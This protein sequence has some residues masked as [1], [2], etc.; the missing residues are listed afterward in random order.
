MT[1]NDQFH[2]E[3]DAELIKENQ[4]ITQRETSVKIGISQERVGHII[5][6]LVYRKICAHWVPCMHTAGC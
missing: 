6:S 1:A 3:Q 5:D 4:Q 2:R